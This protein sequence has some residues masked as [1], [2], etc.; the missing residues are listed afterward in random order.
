MKLIWCY[1][2]LFLQTVG[3]DKCE[4]YSYLYSDK[5]PRKVQNS[6]VAQ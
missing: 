4:N 2:Q 5:Q 6:P 3:R 1:K